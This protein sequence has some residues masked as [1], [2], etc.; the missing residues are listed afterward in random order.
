[1]IYGAF[2]Y[3]FMGIIRKSFF[4]L[5]LK[6]SHVIRRFSAVEIRRTHNRKCKFII[7]K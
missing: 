6:V 1:M 5:Y 3:I 7:K 4:Y 2:S